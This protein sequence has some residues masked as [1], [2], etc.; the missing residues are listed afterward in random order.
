MS[1]PVQ[2]SA[3]STSGPAVQR[4]EAEEEEPEES[5]QGLFVQREAVPEEDEE[6][7]M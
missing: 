1:T 4:Q 5:V 7:P 2:T 6:I 3:L